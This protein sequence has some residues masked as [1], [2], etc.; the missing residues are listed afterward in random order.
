MPKNKTLRAIVGENVTA[1]MA[2]KKLK[3]QQVAT[4]AKKKGTPMDQTSVGRVARVVYPATV[5]TIEA[6]SNGLGVEAWQLLMSG[7]AD[8]NFLAILKAW[9]VS[10]DRGRKLLLFAAEAAAKDDEEQRSK[11]ASA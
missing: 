10:S 3:Q 11:G 6:L 9:S 2:A 1:I 7:G 4:A 8:K 5:D